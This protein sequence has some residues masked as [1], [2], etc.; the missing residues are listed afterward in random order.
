MGNA[1]H[2]A[3]P[4]QIL[5]FDFCYIGKSTSGELYV[6]ILKDDF[7]SYVWLFPCISADA[8]ATANALIEW[9]SSFGNVPQWVSDRGTHFKNQIVRELKE[10]LHCGH[11]FTLAYCPWTNGSVEVVCRE[12]L[13]AMRVLLSEFRLP[14]KL[15]PNLVPLVQSILNNTPL[16]RLNG[17]CPLT[18]FT[19]LSANSPL[20]AIKAEVCGET[21][22]F[23]IPEVRARQLIS[24][25]KLQMALEDM[26]R[27][28][29]E[30]STRTR[31]TRITKHNQ[32]THV[33][34]CNFD[35]GDFVLI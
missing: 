2:A 18:V 11:H 3:K 20:T 35:G 22:T 10:R 27:T 13:R 33:R 12:M 15:W 21:Q 29:F 9:F 5:H 16:S 17:T 14:F 7:S 28:V 26:H 6:L 19:Q 31:Q 25:Q 8:E 24:V 1:L 4:N 34:P 32:R 23:S 30:K